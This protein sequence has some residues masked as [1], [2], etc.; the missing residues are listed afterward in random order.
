MPRTAH[1]LHSV[2]QKTEYRIL[3]AAEEVFA[4][5]GYEGA[6]M[7]Q[8]AER[9]D[10]EKANIYYYFT[11]KEELYQALM[12]KVLVE[13]VDEIRALLKN[14]DSESPWDRI[15][16]FLDVFFRM[17][18]SHRGVISLAFGELLHPP[19]RTK[20]RSPVLVML[21]QLESISKQVVAE[22]IETG[23][24][25]RQ[26]PGQAVLSL[27]GILFFYFL[28]PD[29]RLQR[30]IGGKNLIARPLNT[31]VGPFASRS[32]NYSKNNRFYNNGAS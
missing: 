22:G 17:V 9:A 31:G 13:L 21:E 27:E 8:I 1:K 18:E 28:L 26:D 20:D 4:R 3:D 29:E 16:T 14:L 6:R 24:F 15:D 12:E 30:L 10:V 11:G 2:G 5:F 19:R 7:E 32:A 23:A 25:R